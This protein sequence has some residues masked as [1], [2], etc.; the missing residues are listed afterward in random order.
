MV[1][2]ILL[3]CVYDYTHIMLPDFIRSFKDPNCLT[4]SLFSRSNFSIRIIPGNG[5]GRPRS[6]DA[7]TCLGLYLMWLRSRGPEYF[8]CITFGIT[9]SVCSL[10]IRFAR[11]IMIKILHRNPL[12]MVAMPA[13]G[14]VANL[15]L[16]FNARHPALS[17]V[18]C[19]ADGLKLLIEQ[20]GDVIIQNRFYNGWKH[21]HYVSNVFVFG[22]HGRIIACAINAPGCLH[23]SIIAGF[24]NIYEKL[25][26][27]YDSTGGK[28]V[29]DS[30]FARARFPFLIKS[31]SSAAWSANNAEDVL[32]EREA[33]SA[34]QAAEWG[35][36]ALQ[37]AFPRCKDRMVYEER[38]ERRLIL[39]SYVLVFNFR[40]SLV[41][42]N[43]LLHTYTP[44]LSPEATHILPFLN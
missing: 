27:T 12:A 14:E 24:G 19:I 40:T 25:Q 16:A 17:D 36:R 11:R 8:L 1:P 15:K 29:V 30:A 18:Y 13:D 34:R 28:C 23:D 2:G 10:F 37:S 41:G 33:T 7:E 31:G 43:Q 6:M 21:D 3:M 42:L 4:N 32:L 5:P 35:M 38:G 44:H 39:L 20:S 26:A 22:P 9:G